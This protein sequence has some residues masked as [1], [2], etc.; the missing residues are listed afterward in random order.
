MQTKVREKYWQI[1]L[2]QENSTFFS[3]CGKNAF[4]IKKTTYL[5]TIKTL[6]DILTHPRATAQRDNSHFLTL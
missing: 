2:Y 3:K 1:D 4:L 6:F 5:C